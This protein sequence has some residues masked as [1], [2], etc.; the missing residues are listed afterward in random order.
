MIRS[1]FPE[2]YSPEI[3][4]FRR[5]PLR[6][7]SRQFFLIS[8]LCVGMTGVA[9]GSGF[10]I[11]EQGAKATA[12]GG[13][14]AATANDPSAIFYNV[15]GIAQLRRAEISAGGTGITFSNEFK[16]DPNDAWTSG[17][18]G[19]AR[20]HVFVPPNAYMVMPI[21]D[22]VTFGVGTFANFGLRTNWQEPWV[23][24]FVSRDANVK[25]MTINPAIAF[26]TSDD[27]FAFGIGAD[28]MR[29][30]IVLNR[31]N[32]A[33]NP[34][35]GRIVDVANAFLNSDWNTAWGYNAGILYKPTPTLRLGAAY[36]SHI[37]VDYTGTAA[38]TQISTGNPQ[39]DG[40]VKA[41][42]PPGQNLTTSIDF[43][44][45]ISLGIAT[46]AIP[47]W[48][49]EFDAVQTN[50][51]SFQALDVAFSKTPANNLHSSQ[52]WKDSL[53]YRL[54]ANKAATEHWDVR[55][56][57]LYDKTPQ[58]TEVVGPLLPDADRVGVTFGVGYHKGPF[59]VDVT[60]FLLHF[61]TRST[62]GLNADNFNGTYKTNANLMALN[63]GYKF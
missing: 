34:F 62:Q 44:A 47:T 21:G 35:T 40:V 63:L 3:S 7:L 48:D 61:K 26:R 50:W 14:F 1:L 13:A 22:N 4:Q 20:G 36:R 25:T 52:N 24:R 38:F 15:A 45:I 55:L 17:T 29:S 9:F 33:L 5:F 46:S 37:K 2:P 28:Y 56:G 60:E 31:N 39:F 32:P 16:G 49:L 8:I 57:A 27:K 43:P 10:A 23:G 41:G 19:R 30:H 11:F 18:T 6:L 12:L 51:S 59:V 42:L 54:G 58:P 53:S